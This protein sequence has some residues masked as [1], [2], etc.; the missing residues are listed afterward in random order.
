M[1]KWYGGVGLQ[2]FIVTKMFH[3]QVIAHWSHQYL[4][5]LC[6]CSGYGFE[7]SQTC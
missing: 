4:D 3:A 7:Q 2:T 1:D 5:N 6:G